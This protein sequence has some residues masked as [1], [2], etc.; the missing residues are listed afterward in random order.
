MG[1]YNCINAKQQISPLAHTHDTCVFMVQEKY[2]FL[3]KVSKTF[4]INNSKIWT[5][6][7]FIESAYIPLQLWQVSKHQEPGIHCR[8]KSLRSSG[9]ISYA[10]NLTERTKTTMI[11][12]FCCEACVPNAFLKTFWHRLVQ[13]GHQFT[14]KKFVPNVVNWVLAT[15]KFSSFVL[16]CW[17]FIKTQKLLMGCRS[18][19]VTEQ[20]GCHYE[21]PIH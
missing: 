7:L 13:F 18:A 20:T 11:S 4:F 1:K 16:R 8:I 5:I 19:L 17:V 21:I 10:I 2:Q 3:T 15:C 6:S 14:R 9:V 12:I